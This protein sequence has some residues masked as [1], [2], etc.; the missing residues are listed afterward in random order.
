MH[1][2]TLD[3]LFCCL[4]PLSPIPHEWSSRPLAP[5]LKLHA[6]MQ[7]VSIWDHIDA[8]DLSSE[9][10]YVMYECMHRYLDQLRRSSGGEYSAVNADIYV[11]FSFTKHLALS[12]IPLK[13]LQS[14]R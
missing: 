9:S 11:L 12:L 3:C 13:G 1:F 8:G 4:T 2:T 7:G 5:L 10:A 14:I 6:G